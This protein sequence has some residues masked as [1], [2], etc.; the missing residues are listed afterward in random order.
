LQGNFEPRIN[1]GLKDGGETRVNG[2]N[3]TMTPSWV[4]ID[5]IVFRKSHL[6]SEIDG[7]TNHK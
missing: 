2:F 5:T 6:E 7:I 1:Q 4:V 3:L